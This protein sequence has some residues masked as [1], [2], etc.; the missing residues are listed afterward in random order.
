MFRVIVRVTPDSR[1][2]QGFTVVLTGDTRD[3]DT[4]TTHSTKVG[5]FL[6]GVLD[7]RFEGE[8]VHHTISL[9]PFRG[10]IEDESHGCEDGVDE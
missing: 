10:T 9:P 5:V 4:P 1:F 6:S 3:D 2:S 7:A 8:D